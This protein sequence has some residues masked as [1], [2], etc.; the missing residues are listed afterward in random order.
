MDSIRHDT[1]FQD[2]L[3]TCLDCGQDFTFTA[4]E[5]R[6]YLAKGLTLYPKRC[7][8]CR[9]KRKLT[10]NRTGAPPTSTDEVIRRGLKEIERW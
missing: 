9:C 10:I 6:F 5:I 1:Q 3:L 2:R 4:G 8:E 7:P